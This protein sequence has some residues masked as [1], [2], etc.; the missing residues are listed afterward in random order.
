MKALW[1]N[2]FEKGKTVGQAENQSIGIGSMVNTDTFSK[3][4]VLRMG[5]NVLSR[6]SFSHLAHYITIAEGVVFAQFDNGDVYKSTDSGATWSNTSATTTNAHG[7]GLIYF[8]GLGGTGYVFAFR[9]SI[10]DYYSLFSNTWTAGW[11]TGLSTAGSSMTPI[12]ANH[13]PFIFPS[14]NG[15]YFGNG[16]QLGYIGAGT[17]STFDPATAGSGYVYD[18]AILT[19]PSGWIIKTLAFYPPNY[20][21]IGCGSLTN[22]QTSDLIFWDTVTKNKYYPPITLYSKSQNRENGINQLI[23]RNNTLYAV[24]GGTHSIFKTDGSSYK[25]MSDLSLHTVYRQTEGNELDAPMVLSNYP[26]AIEVI[27]DRI[28]TGYA[29]PPSNYISPFDSTFG[30]YPLGVWTMLPDDGEVECTYVPCV[31]GAG[32]GDNS[33]SNNFA[34]GAIK[35]LTAGSY[36]VSWKKASLALPSSPVYY[37]DV[38][39][40]YGYLTD[41]AGSVV[42]GVRNTVI[43]SPLWEIGSALTPQTISNI[44]IQLIKNLEATQRIEVLYRTKTRDNFTSLQTFTGD[45]TQAYYAVDD[46][47]IGATQFL[48]IQ[49]KL[50]QSSSSGTFDTPELRTVKIS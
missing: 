43:E 26:S 19:L 48:Q 25:L 41:E 6:A 35:A 23:N 15:F 44:E 16:N 17:S 38:V 27:G 13:Y 47:P 11:Q 9:D 3:K 28:F 42:N 12:S 18:P 46:N 29:T 1:I 14:Q 22:Y 10:I 8:N 37:I 2:T 39:S 31:N 21:A 33:P 4:G 30:V 50:G 36:L 32:F 40:A 24:S 5:K 34:I 20:L 49:V 45:G 7:N